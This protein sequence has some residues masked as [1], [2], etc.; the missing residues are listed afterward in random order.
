[1]VRVTIPFAND[2]LRNAHETQLRPLRPL[3]QGK[4]FPLY[5]QRQENRENTNGPS[6]AHFN[7]TLREN[8]ICT[9]YFYL[10]VIILHD[11]MITCLGCLS[12]SIY[13]YF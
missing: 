1:M 13:H 6:A 3:L 7:R 2:C 9:Q 4:Y 11:E 5:E 8:I 12:V 10:T